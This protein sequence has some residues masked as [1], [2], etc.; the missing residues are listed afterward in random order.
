MADR[1]MTAMSQP[2]AVTLLWGEDAFWLR[3]TALAMLGA[4]RATEVDAAEWT[5][6]EQ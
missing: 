5:G 3:E 6:R 4:I 2:D 1:T